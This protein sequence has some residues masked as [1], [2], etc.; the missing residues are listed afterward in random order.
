[1]IIS[2]IDEP[3]RK[4]AGLAGFTYPLSFATWIIASAA[5]VH[6][7]ALIVGGIPR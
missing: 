1:M 6:P 2:T 4:T 3:Q 7:P 5:T